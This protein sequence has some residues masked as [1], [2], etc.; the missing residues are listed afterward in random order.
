MEEKLF[1]LV[2][3]GMDAVEEAGKLLGNLPKLWSKAGLSDRHLILMTMLDA[4][5]VE[6]KEEKRI[7]AIKPKPAFR[8]LFEI[9]NTR[10]GSGVVLIKE[11]TPARGN[12]GA[13]GLPCSWWRRGR[14]ELHLKHGIEV[15][16][17]A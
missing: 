9:A 5:Y 11:E 6:C 17:A 7:V 4:V 16:L 8:P 2:V 3:P 14:V 13:P 12:T 1:D 15:L 10:S